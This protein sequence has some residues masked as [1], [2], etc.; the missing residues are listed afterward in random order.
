[1]EAR[2]LLADGGMLLVVENPA[3]TLRIEQARRYSL[4]LSRST[5]ATEI[6]YTRGELDYMLRHAG[7]EDILW[8]PVAG[9]SR[10]LLKRWVRGALRQARIE[11]HFLSV[12]YLIAAFKR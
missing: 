7:F 10:N 2:R 4:H 6:A 5:N 1:M 12:G 8:E 9:F 11:H 3:A